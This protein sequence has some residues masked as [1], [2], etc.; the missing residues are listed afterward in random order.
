MKLY[1]TLKS[2]YAGY[3]NYNHNLDNRNHIPNHSFGMLLCMRTDPLKD[4]I[5]MRFKIKRIT[6]TGYGFLARVGIHIFVMAPILSNYL[7]PPQTFC[8]ITTSEQIHIFIHIFM[9]NF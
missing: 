9:N 7:S 6:L 3:L 8:G 5:A 1:D 2:S 4:N